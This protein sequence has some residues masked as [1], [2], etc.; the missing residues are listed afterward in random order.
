L[1]AAHRSQVRDDCIAVPSGSDK[2]ARRLSLRPAG[3]IARP[4]RPLRLR[5]PQQP[6]LLCLELV[7]SEHSRI[8]KPAEAFKVVE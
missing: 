5:R 8:A 3:T 4:A 1:L 2:T 6:V 7:L